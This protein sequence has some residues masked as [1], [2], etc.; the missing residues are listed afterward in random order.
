[1]TIKKTAGRPTREI[2]G[3]S[4]GW[5]EFYSRGE[6]RTNET[7]SNRGSVRDMIWGILGLERSKKRREE[8]LRKLIL[9]AGETFEKI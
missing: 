3:I 2:E 9:S 4:Q 7:P 8:S 6:K 5:E 1:M